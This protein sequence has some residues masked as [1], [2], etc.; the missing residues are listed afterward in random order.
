MY[1]I[2]TYGIYYI[3]AIKKKKMSIN[4]DKQINKNITHNYHNKEY[5][6]LYLPNS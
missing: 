2:M 4:L 5:K 3:D 6:L 1:Y